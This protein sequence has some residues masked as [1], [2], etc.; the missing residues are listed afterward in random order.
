MTKMLRYQTSSGTTGAC[1]IYT[2]ESECPYPNLKVQVDGTNGYVKLSD[3]A[4]DP[5]KTPIKVYVNSS[6]KTFSALTQSIPTGSLRVTSDITFTVPA[7]IT[8]ITL[9]EPTA[10]T[11]NYIRVSP[12]STHLLKW[13][14]FTVGGEI[15]MWFLGCDTHR[16]SAFWTAVAHYSKD[17]TLSWSPEINNHSTNMSCP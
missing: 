15:P 14:G 7:G 9:E 12:N 5:N 1:A 6:G 17:V 16:D 11:P 2:T 8:V 3:N 4:S 10:K 13:S